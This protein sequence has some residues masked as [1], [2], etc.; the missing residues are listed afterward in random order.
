MVRIE[1]DPETSG[2]VAFDRLDDDILLVHYSGDV[3]LGF[4][5]QAG[6]CILRLLK[7]GSSR[8]LYDVGESMPLFSPVD[9]LD[10]VRRIGQAGGKQARFAYLA[11]ENMFTKYFMLIEAAAYNEGIEVKFFSEKTLAIEWLKDS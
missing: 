8:V 5:E 4:V 7:E 6:D 2:R 1:R 10:E 3:S 11:P 9:L